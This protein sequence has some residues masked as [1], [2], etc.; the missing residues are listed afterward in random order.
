MKKRWLSIWNDVANTDGELEYSAI[1]SAYE[2]KHRAYHNLEHVRDCLAQLDQIDL[3]SSQ[4][5]IELALWYHDI[6]YNTRSSTNEEDSARKA[7]QDIKNA[8]VKSSIIEN[9]KRLILATKHDSIPVIQNEKILVDI[10]LSILGRSPEKFH[11]YETKIRREYEWVPEL[12]FREK[13][14]EILQGF[15]NR[16]YIFLTTQFREKYESQARQNIISS[17]ALLKTNSSKD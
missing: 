5:E 9:V 2:E 14:I 10:D 4:C 8:G 11:E 12:V 16:R 1:I 3:Q 6:V 17:I 7:V 15:L 13:R